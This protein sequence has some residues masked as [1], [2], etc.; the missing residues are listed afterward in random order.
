[1]L[2]SIVIPPTNG[3][4]AFAL[5]F[6]SSNRCAGG[7]HPADPRNAAPDVDRHVLALHEHPE[8]FR[9]LKEN[10]ELIDTMVPEVIRWQTPLAYIRRTERNPSVGIGGRLRRQHRC[11]AD[12]ARY[13]D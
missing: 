9:K 5:N 10:P 6:F 4:E 1:M 12:K 7:P 8:Q 3:C 13:F 2:V 11:G